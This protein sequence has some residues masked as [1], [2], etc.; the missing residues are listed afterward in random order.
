MVADVLV[1]SDKGTWLVEHRSDIDRAEALWLER[2]AEFD[3]A[4]GWLEDGQLSCAHWLMW[5]RWRGR[6]LTRSCRWRTSFGDG[7]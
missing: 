6:P 4:L 1:A 3:L 2:L 7:R 5:R